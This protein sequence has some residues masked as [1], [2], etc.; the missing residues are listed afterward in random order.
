MRV[1]RARRRHRWA[2]LAC[3]LPA[4]ALATPGSWSTAVGDVV[5]GGSGQDYPS[6]PMLAPRTGSTARLVRVQWSYR[7]P[8]GRR[9]DASLC[10]GRRCIALAQPRG[11]ST[12][13]AGIPTDQP[14]Q[15]RFRLRAGDALPVRV[16]QV[17]LVVD[18]R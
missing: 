6:V 7:L 9:V 10:A 4:L 1:T 2:L 12:A 13:L 11:Q 16:R 8:P 18:Y 5:I 15:F 3:A 14:L 17:R